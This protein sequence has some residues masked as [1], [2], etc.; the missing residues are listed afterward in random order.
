MGQHMRAV[1][2]RVTVALADPE[3]RRRPAQMYEPEVTDGRM[4]QL[5]EPGLV[6]RAG[7]R[8]ADDWLAA[9]VPGHPPTVA[10]QCTQPSEVA[11][12]ASP[13]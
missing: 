5:V 4:S 13:D 9:L 10:M 12:A 11:E 1:P 6:V 2:E 7:G 3:A 8:L